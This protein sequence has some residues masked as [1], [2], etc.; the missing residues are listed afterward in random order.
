MNFIRTQLRLLPSSFLG[1]EIVQLVQ[2]QDKDWAAGDQFRMEEK[3]LLSLTASR[4]ILRPMHPLIPVV[5]SLA[6]AYLWG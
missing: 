2:R 5:F 1:F 6:Y 4:P 3:N